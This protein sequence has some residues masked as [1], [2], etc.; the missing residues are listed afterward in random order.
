MRNW[1]HKKERTAMN[2]LIETIDENWVMSLCIFGLVMVPAA[3]L[4]LQGCSSESAKAQTGCN[5][6]N[7]S[8]SDGARCY[9]IYCDGKAIGG[10]CQ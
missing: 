4:L 6:V 8:A 3:L 5:A 2:K 9:A 7:F 1:K 10:N